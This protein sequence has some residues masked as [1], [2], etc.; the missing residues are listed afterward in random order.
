MKQVILISSC[1]H[2]LEMSGHALAVTYCHV[3]RTLLF[4]FSEVVKKQTFEKQFCIYNIRRSVSQKRL[5]NLLCGEHVA[6]L[7]M[8]L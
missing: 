7:F 8:A 1:F 4:L 5:S 3:S 6:S 2:C